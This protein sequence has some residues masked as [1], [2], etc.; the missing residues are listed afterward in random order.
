MTAPP[1]VRIVRRSRSLARPVRV[2][3]F[4][5]EVSIHFTWLIISVLIAWSLAT[6]AFP[7]LHAGLPPASYWSMA[8]GVVI[9][10][11]ASIIL[12]ELAHT[13]VGRAF[14]M[15]VHRITLFLLGG[16]AELDEEP[17][18]PRDE[19]FMALAGPAASLLLSLVFALAA[20]ALQSIAASAEAVIALGYLA[21]FNLVL[22]V[23]NLTPAYPLDGGRVLRAA[24][25]M[26]TGRPETATRVAA[27]TSQGFAG[28]L[29]LAGVVVAVSGHPAGFWWILIGLFVLAAATAALDHLAARRHL[30]GRPVRELMAHRVETAPSD[31]RLEA[32]VRHRLYATRHGVYPI[33]EMDRLIGVVE[34]ADILATPRDR[35]AQT[36]LGDICAPLDRTRFVAPGEDAFA[37]LERM[38]TERR[39]RM[40]VIDRGALVGM[41]TLDD[42]LQRLALARRFEPE[43][44]W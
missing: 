1:P 12:H 28:I 34:P 8:A 23:F 38:R 41:V 31:M 3:L 15:S 21:T 44:A 5:V 30:A 37:V 20:A 39:P 29:V 22:A 36:T 17:K 6:G 25:W 42:L 2:R 10:L 7:R 32:F 9:G 11:A 33:V 13:L 27:R 14:G 16:M 4:G 40:L 19:L 43:P 24:L 26:I 35:W 18:A